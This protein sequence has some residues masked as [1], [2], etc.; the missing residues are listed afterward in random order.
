MIPV[1][2]LCMLAI[3]ML[4]V[5]SGLGG[6]HGSKPAQACCCLQTPF[7]WLFNFCA[8]GWAELHIYFPHTGLAVSGRKYF[9]LIILGKGICSTRWPPQ[10]VQLF[11]YT[12]ATLRSRW[13]WY[14][15]SFFYNSGGDSLDSLQ[16]FMSPSSPV[17]I[18]SVLSAIA[19]VCWSVHWF[20]QSSIM[21]GSAFFQ[22][23]KGLDSEH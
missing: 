17:P 1:T 18:S 20:R 11:I 15:F 9:K 13:H 19:G 14:E 3:T 6:M 12:K 22:L 8:L 23:K 2:G 10:P 16:S 7:C 21:W 5:P 4:H